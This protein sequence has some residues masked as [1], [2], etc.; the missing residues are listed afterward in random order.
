MGQPYTPSSTLTDDYRCFLLNPGLT[1]DRFIEG[2]EVKPGNP[3]IVHHVVVNQVTALQAAQAQSQDGQDG[4]P[5]WPCF[6]GTGL[7][8]VSADPSKARPSL[9]RVLPQLQAKGVHTLKLLKAYQQ[10]GSDPLKAIQAYGDAGGDT[11]RLMYALAETGLLG[12]MSDGA[13]GSTDD[14]LDA[15]LGTVF[16]IGAWVPGAE[17]TV[18]P[19]GTGRRLEK[20]NF[21][22]MQVHYNTLAGRAPDLTRM[23]VQYAPVQAELK[24]LKSLSVVAPVE[25]PCAATR[26]DPSCQRDVVVARAVQQHGPQAQR[27]VD[28]LLALC[29]Q[30]LRDYA[31]E[32]AEAATSTCDRPVQQDVLAVGVTLHLHTR[33]Q[34]ASLVLNAGTP[35][36][37]VLLDISRWDFHWQGVY[38]YEAPIALKKGDVLRV[39]C[40]WDNTR[41]TQPKYI[42]WGEGSQDEMCLAGLTVMASRPTPDTR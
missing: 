30:T 23:T 8:T 20:G 36:E 1:T 25:I 24:P 19:S 26:T 6:G 9:L 34:A 27:R 37:Q 22:V 31:S 13:H 38:W 16:G 39:S 33:G 12:G 3:E 41:D 32:R 15:A 14:A 40:T 10:A 18:F 28:G 4:Q 5:G 17:A 2:F 42:V 21:L 35:E 29:G 11:Q 7:D